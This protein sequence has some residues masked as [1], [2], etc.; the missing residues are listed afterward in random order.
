M[1][2][3]WLFTILVTVFSISCSVAAMQEKFIKHT[4]LKG[5]TI[6]QI[7]QKYKV[8]P[9]DIYK[10]NQD[11]QKGIQLNSVL[12]IPSNGQIASSTVSQPVVTNSV[13]TN[14]GT[15]T[16]VALPKETLYSISKQYGVTVEAIQNANGD[17]LKNGLKIGQKIIIPSADGSV[18]ASTPKIDFSNKTV[19]SSEPK[20]VEKP[21]AV[22]KPSG[23]YH[24]ILPKETKY[25]I[26]RKY[27]VSIAEL[28]SINP[29]IVNGFPIGLKL[30]LP[31]NAK[32]SEE[33]TTSTVADVIKPEVKTEVKAVEEKSADTPASTSTKIYFQEYLVKPKETVL[34]IATDF[35][36][37]E[38]ELIKLNP[39]LKKGIKLGMLL[40]VPKISDNEKKKP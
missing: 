17:A 30:L 2:N 21:V 3:Q 32:I 7:S 20:T 10:L 39:E 4:V 40:R 36:I 19:T 27:E 5:E 24:V 23:Q 38:N 33:T 18:A 37:T 35:A 15:T 12:L 9:Y 16:H 28:E 1:K 11:S 13:A 34:S 8:T 14:S 25:S 6:T 29:Q 26:S 22:S 31:S